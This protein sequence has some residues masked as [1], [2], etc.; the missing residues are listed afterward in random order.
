M[1]N[2]YTS[3]KAAFWVLKALLSPSDLR[4][5][6]FLRVVMMVGL[7]GSGKSTVAQLL[8]KCYGFERFSTDQ[9]RTK[10]LFKGQEHRLGKEH[11]MVMVS[12]YKVYEELGQRVGRALNSGKKCVIDGTNLDDKRMGILGTALAQVPVE[13]V[14]FVMLKP[15]EWIMRRRLLGEGKPEA[16]KWWSVYKYW[17]KYMKDGHASFPNDKNFPRVRKLSVRR[18]ALR[19]FDWVPEIKAIFWDVDGTLYKDTPALR[20]AFDKPCIEEFGER[21]GLKGKRAE[22]EFFKVYEKLHSKTQTLNSVGI[23]GPKFIAKTSNE[24]DYEKY[25]KKDKKLVK[26]FRSLKQVKH[27]V[28]SNSSNEATLKKLE[29]LGLSEK[30]FEKVLA[31][32]DAPA[33]KPDPRA[34]KW[35]L[36]KSGFRAEQVLMVGDREETDLLPAKKLGMRTAYVWGVSR[37][38]DVSLPTV[39]EV[40]ELFGK[41]L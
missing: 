2:N 36:R 16:A 25:L 37:E 11:E 24:M 26:M 15:P 5:I 9:I 38:A 30:I 40:A 8:A 27:F 20:R 35:A 7:P 10:E 4:R 6:E 12:R 18:Y 14:A 1:K 3:K 13:Q 41:E 19:T 22:K 23:D 39:Y 32:Y 31:T 17:R 21:M 29:T 34:F 33:T 28:F